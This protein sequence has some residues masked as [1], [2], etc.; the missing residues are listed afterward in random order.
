MTDV[1]ASTRILATA[2]PVVGQLRR[3]ILIG[4]SGYFLFHVIL[5]LVLSD[6]LVLDEA[7]QVLLSQQLQWGYG[8]QPPLYNWLQA[9]VFSLLG[10]N[11]AALAVLKN[12]LLLGGFWLMFIAV[13]RMTGDDLPGLEAA[14]SLML[15]PEICWEAQR[16][17]THSVVLLTTTLATLYVLIRLLQSRHIG[18]YL[19]L[20]VSAAGGILSKYNYALFLIPALLAAATLRPFR[21]AVLSWKM[22]LTLLCIAVLTWAHV[23]WSIE[24]RAE[25]LS[26]REDFFRPDNTPLGSLGEIASGTL[27]YLLGALI[28]YG[29]F[30][31]HSFRLP[32]PDDPA[33]PFE[34]LMFRIAIIGLAALTVGALTAGV[35]SIQARWLQP[36]M[37]AIVAWLALRVRDALTPAAVKGLATVAVL[38]GLA[39]IAGLSVRTLHPPKN[40]RHALNAPFDALAGQIREAGFSGGTIVAADKQMGGNLH[41]RFPG[42]RTIVPGL[43]FVAPLPSGDR[44][45]VWNVDDPDGDTDR[46]IAYA[47]QQFGPRSTW[48]AEQ[49]IE[50]PLKYTDRGRMRLG[51]VLLRG[52]T[53]RLIDEPAAEK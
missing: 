15:L 24:H 21:R 37:L 12:L 36:L 41:L 25:T 17:L 32:S 46:A 30:F 44:L 18:W 16:D 14:L 8:P 34:R 6:S 11:L 38:A 27:R 49:V 45:V 53:A 47:A 2:Q 9:G 5:R 33:K 52:D 43:T 51:F 20:G 26:Q 31:F 22:L 19:L 48:P 4:L 1:V 39:V 42:S 10:T 3:V 23:R 7:E 40:T 13:R 35:T 50:A 28:F 29:L